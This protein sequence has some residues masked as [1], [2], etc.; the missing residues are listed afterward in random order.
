M[1]V[2]RWLRANP[3]RAAAWICVGL[4]VIALLV[5]FH[6]IAGT[7][8][9]AEQMPYLLSGGIGGALLIAFGATL[10]LS[11]DMR[12]EWHTLDRIEKRLEALEQQQS[13]GA[14]AA[15]SEQPVAAE[16]V[17][18]ETP[19]AIETPAATGR[20]GAGRRRARSTRAP[21]A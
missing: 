6:G 17:T 16:P 9:P 15:I 8:Y 1:D 11:A 5:G 2:R 19:A 12:D 21:D 20:N 7:G 4:G 3:D 14:T 18:V 10:L 13:D